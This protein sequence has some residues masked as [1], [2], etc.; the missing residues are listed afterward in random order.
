MSYWFRNVLLSSEQKHVLL[1]RRQDALVLAREKALEWRTEQRRIR[2]ANVERHIDNYLSALTCSEYEKVLACALLYL[3]E[4]FKKS[5]E[6]GLGSSDPLMLKFFVQV[7]LDCFS[8]QE[9]SIRCELYLRADQNRDDMV[10]YWSSALK[11]PVSCF[12]YTHHDRRTEGSKTRDDYFGVCAVRCGN[13]DVSL[14]LIGLARSYC[15]KII[16]GS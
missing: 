15:G 16:K 5:K 9:R 7:L 2:C 4:G 3:G 14:I 6:T 13:V 10:S 1:G 8:V 11:L 12:R